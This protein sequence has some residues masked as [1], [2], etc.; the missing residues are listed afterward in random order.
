MPWLPNL[1]LPNLGDRSVL[2]RMTH[3]G[4]RKRADA[5]CKNWPRRGPPPL[6]PPPRGGAVLAAGRA[7]GLASHPCRQ[8]LGQRG[9]RPRPVKGLL[10]RAA[11]A[12]D[13]TRPTALGQS[14][15]D[16]PLPAAGQC[17]DFWVQVI[18]QRRATRPQD[19]ASASGD[20]RPCAKPSAAQENSPNHARPR[21]ATAPR[22]S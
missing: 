16:A 17:D 3:A 14:D 12:L 1:G 21:A 8:P 20:C 11:P 9:G 7:R 13:R 22:F 10:R 6:T 5:V 18:A 19:E 2:G 4:L 15:P